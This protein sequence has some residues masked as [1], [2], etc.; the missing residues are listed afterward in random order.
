ML[1]PYRA[2]LL[3]ADEHVHLV[4]RPHALTFW[5]GAGRGLVVGLLLLAVA[6]AIEQTTFLPPALTRARPLLSLGLVLL[7]VVA[8]ASVLQGWLRWRAHEIVVTDRRVIRIAGVFSKDVIDYS[9]D[10]ITDLRLRQSWLGRIFG[11]GDVDI[12][13]AAEATSHPR[14][15]FPLVAGPIAFMHAVEEQRERR[16]RGYSDPSSITQPIGYV[17]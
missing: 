9:L 10:A 7:S 6:L 1:R 16:R 14:E 5:L 2:G 15:T 17:R 4:A 3:A 11:Y 13:T 12:L 8:F